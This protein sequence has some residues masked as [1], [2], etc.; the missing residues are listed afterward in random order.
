MI[1][2]LY[3]IKNGIFK[4]GGTDYR[5]KKSKGTGEGDMRPGEGGG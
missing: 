2:L 3:L 5:P 4:F 1:I